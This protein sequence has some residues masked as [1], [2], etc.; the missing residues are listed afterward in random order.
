MHLWIWAILLLAVG[1]ALAVMEIFFPSAGILGFLSAL[2]VFSAIVM[3]FNH[4]PVT[5][6]LVLLGALVGLPTVIVLGFKY[7]PKTAMGRRVLLIAPTSEEVLPTDPDRDFL[8]G[9]IGRVGRAKSKM[10][11]S[12]VIS[13][14]G[15]TVDA[16][17]ESLPVEAGQ[18]VRVVQVRG[19]EVIVRPVEDDSSDAP[20]ADPLKQTFDDPFDLPPA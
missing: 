2:A 9:L 6:V 7:W 19:R 18:S 12:G 20:P 10:L 8:R 5:G 11:L 1:S 15:R 16:V 4:D 3:G 14:D 13:I 17:S